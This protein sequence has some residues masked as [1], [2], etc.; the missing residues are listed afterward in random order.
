MTGQMDTNQFAKQQTMLHGTITT[1][2]YTVR[3]DHNMYTLATD[4]QSINIL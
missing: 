2:I 1:W 3:Q 4:T